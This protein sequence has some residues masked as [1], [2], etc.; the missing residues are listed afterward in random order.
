MNKEDVKKARI[1]LN[2]TQVEFGKLL[3]VN[4]QTVFRWEKGTR[5]VRGPAKMIIMGMLGE[6]EKID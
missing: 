1:G 5:K 6:L 3:G 2:L 4:G